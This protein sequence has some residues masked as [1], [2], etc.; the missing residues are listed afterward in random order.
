MKIVHLIYDDVKNPWLAGG[1]ARATKEFNERLARQHDV[2]VITGGFPG[3]KD[4]T[5][6]GV[7]Y[8]RTGSARTYGL[9]RLLFALQARRLAQRYDKDIVIDDFTPFSPTF[10]FW[11][12][13]SPVLCVLRNLFQEEV[14]RKHPLVGWAVAGVERLCLRRY[15]S[16]LVFS[17]SMRRKLETTLTRQYR[18]VKIFEIPRG[19]DLSSYRTS[20]AYGSSGRGVER[21]G[22]PVLFLGRV[23]MYQKGLDILLHGYALFRDALVRKGRR[24]PRLVIAGN[25]SSVDKRRIGSLARKLGLSHDVVL[26][27]R[28]EGK[29]KADMLR[30]SLF[31]AMPSRYE[32]WGAVAI[33]AA[34]AGRA[35]IGSDISGLRDAVVDRQT[36][37]LFRLGSDACS[38]ARN[39]SEKML[40]LHGHP[41]L[42]RK[43]E[44]AAAERAQRFDWSDIFRQQ[45]GLYRRL[46]KG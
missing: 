23:E 46:S 38:S 36:G 22:S 34:A 1:G 6:S 19:I 37:L 13:E 21:D 15:G 30:K 39:L 43:L 11:N 42:R 5:I 31:V 27:G 18:Q 44:E 4:E 41:A 3:A 17:P 7:R 33:E 32:S 29:E 2:T 20:G 45:E 24:F 12:Q 14:K 10:S 25:A 28:V 40:F 16:F 35:V 26:A 9:S 8:V